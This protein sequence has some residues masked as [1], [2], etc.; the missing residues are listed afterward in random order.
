MWSADTRIVIL[1]DK[2]WRGI[3][4]SERRRHHWHS[5]RINWLRL[6]V[7]FH[8]FISTVS[9]ETASQ[10][11]LGTIS[12]MINSQRTFSASN[13]RLW[14]R[15]ACYLMARLTEMSST[16]AKPEGDGAAETTFELDCFFSMGLALAHTYSCFFSYASSTD[17]I[18]FFEG[19]S[20]I[21][22]ATFSHSTEIW[23]ITVKT[24]VE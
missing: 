6:I 14:F 1:T 8:W 17:K 11:I 18:F 20:I 2:I 22:P 19:F 3:D 13:A 23:L 4:W 10:C 15:T 16:E 7:W 9:A 24:V 5:K 12:W 21:L